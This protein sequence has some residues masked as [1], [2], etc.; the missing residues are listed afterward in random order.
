M[1]EEKEKL[2]K[3]L[4]FWRNYGEQQIKLKEIAEA[5][6]QKVKELC[7]LKLKSRR[8]YYDYLKD[9]NYYLP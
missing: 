3:S 8:N 4:K 7:I 9:Q 5:K 1:A 2:K 6:I